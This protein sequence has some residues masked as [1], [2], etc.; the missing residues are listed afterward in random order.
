MGRKNKRIKR[1][2]FRERNKKVRRTLFEFVD[3]VPL[4]KRRK[5]SESGDLLQQESVCMV[6]IKTKKKNLPKEYH[7]CGRAQPCQFHDSKKIEDIPESLS[8]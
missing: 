4:P 6:E 8:R 5:R 1:K 7:I 3:E 2:S